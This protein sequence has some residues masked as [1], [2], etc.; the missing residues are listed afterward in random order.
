MKRLL[1]APYVVAFTLFGGPIAIA[2]TAAIAATSP[3]PGAITGNL[4]T[5]AKTYTGNYKDTFTN[6]GTNYLTVCKGV[7]GS[8]AA[9]PTYGYGVMN[10]SFTE[11]KITGAPYGNVR[12]EQS[13][14]GTDWYPAVYYPNTNYQDT[15]IIDSAAA[16]RSR[17]YRVIGGMP[18]YRLNIKL[19]GT[20][21]SSWVSQYFWQ[22]EQI[23]SVS[24]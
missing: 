5:A 17:T 6:A 21:T 1:C 7:N 12:V 23:M 2:Q 18:Y 4:L 15:T 8:F 10:I 22:R 3:T 14:N 24:K 19:T 9:G 11:T 20:Q 16:T 13:P